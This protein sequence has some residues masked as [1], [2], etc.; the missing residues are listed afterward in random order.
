M[1]A[2]RTGFQTIPG[3]L[4][5]YLDELDLK[6]KDL[7]AALG[8]SLRTVYN[9]EYSRKRANR[10]LLDKLAKVLNQFAEQ[11]P[12]LNNLT[13]TADHFIDHPSSFAAVF[14]Q[15]VLLNDSS[16]FF[17][18]ENP[19]AGPDFR[20]KAPGSHVAIP[21]AGDYSGAES[22]VLLNRLHS[23]VKQVGLEEIQILHNRTNCQVYVHSISLFEH[24]ESGEVFK[25]AASSDLNLS[26]NRLTEV[27]SVYD[28]ELVA[29]FLQSG[30]AP[31]PR[32]SHPA[33]N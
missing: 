8:V 33:C 9:I 1:P 16:F 22:Q 12:H 24:P 23:T 31:R 17:V 4:T 18:G 25:F 20:W 29:E 21:F 14:L 3:H 28:Y 32:K 30:T 13:L 10:D 26:G 27:Q 7:A 19:I 2:P 6:R 11:Q 5:H 15:S